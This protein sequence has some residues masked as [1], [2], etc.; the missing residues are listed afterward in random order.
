MLFM[1]DYCLL[2]G[3]LMNRVFLSK[4]WNLVNADRVAGRRKYDW[5]PVSINR[6]AKSFPGKRKRT[7]QPGRNAG[8]GKHAG[9]VVLSTD[10]PSPSFAAGQRAGMCL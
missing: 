5:H 2:Q 9:F 8:L 1:V 7:R 3:L 4:S 6:S 10:R